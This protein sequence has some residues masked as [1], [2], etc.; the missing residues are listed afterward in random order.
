MPYNGETCHSYASPKGFAGIS[1]F[2]LEINYFWYVKKQ[3]YRLSFNASFLIILT[4]SKSL[5][6]VSKNKVA[7]LM[8]SARLAAMDVLKKRY[9]EKK[10][11]I[12]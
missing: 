8:M 3:S 1:I 11:L 2:S 4:F 9:F 7:M 10:A 5:K 6:V 12:L